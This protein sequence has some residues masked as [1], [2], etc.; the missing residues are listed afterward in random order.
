M[1][2]N[3]TLNGTLDK[4]LNGTFSDFLNSAWSHHGDHPEKTAE[5]LE[6]GLELCTSSADVLALVN[7]T[8][9]LYSEHLHKFIEGERILRHIGKSDF[10]KGTSAEF[11]VARAIMA[12]RLSEGSVDP[13]VDRLGLTPADLTR[14]LATAASTLAIRDSVRAASYLSYA[15]EIAATL[16]LSTSD[17]VARSLAIAGNNSASSLEEL[18]ERTDAQTALM[19]LA[20]ETGRKFWELAGTWMEIERAEYRWAKSCLAAANDPA[21]SS[22]KLNEAR[23]HAELCLKICEENQAPAL[24]FFF[25]YEC[26]ASIEDQTTEKKE[27]SVKLA[28]EWFEKLSSDD[29]AWA[30]TSLDALGSVTA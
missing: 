1:T 17:G 13:R 23:H 26:L 16:E 19:L 5:N 8:T 27:A 18:A 20:A 25:A 2:L 15:L 6:S 7:L 21:Q 22:Q 29:Q 4:T 12:L 3:G 14:S 9:H 24:E 10:T 30:K 28:R 11:A